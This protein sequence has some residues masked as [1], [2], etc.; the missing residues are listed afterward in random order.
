MNGYVDTRGKELH[1]KHKK[2]CEELDLLREAKKEGSFEYKL[3]LQE[4]HTHNFEG[5]L[6]LSINHNNWLNEQLSF[7]K[8]KKK[9]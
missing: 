6:F 1:E 9:S 2:L 8:Q 4:I 3:K 7:F 5:A